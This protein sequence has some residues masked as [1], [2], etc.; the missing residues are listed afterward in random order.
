MPKIDRWLITVVPIAVLFACRMLGL[1]L[2]IPVF[3]IYAGQLLHATPGLIGV[4]LGA[5]GLGQGLLQLPM[6]LLSDNYGRKSILTY[7]FILLGLGSVIG[8]VTNSIW[9]IIA[10]R[11][12]Q[13]S[14]AIGSVLMALLAD[15][16]TV[17]ARTKGMA[18]IGSTIGLSF[19]LA[20]VVSPVI[21]AHFGL[22]GIFY[23]SL[24]LAMLGLIIV[25]YIKAPPVIAVA[26]RM[27]WWLTLRERCVTSLADKQLL[28]LNFGI[29]FQ[30]WI[31]TAT[32]YV[33]PLVLQKHIASGNLEHISLFYLV[34][35]L[36]A[37]ALMIPLIIIS[38]KHGYIRRVLRGSIVGTAIIQGVLAVNYQH[39]SFLCMLMVLYFAMFNV[40]EALLPSLTSKQAHQAH[41]GTAMGIYSTFQ[42]LGI[43]A[44][45]I[46]SGVIFA[47]AGYQ[48]VFYLNSVVAMIWYIS[49]TIV[50]EEMP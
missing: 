17:Q 2:L 14:G 46:V 47:H 21:A 6:G 48:A 41:K 11:I 50:G 25:H 27:N 40:L 35:L 20:M 12:L 8:A 31:L 16:T 34:I 29:F 42:F 43:F 1:F 38:E 18:I 28:T 44:G 7:G 32:F 45:G 5:Y 9:G 15:I 33:L 30:H 36:S 24:L 37:F 26:T 13:G 49:T 39:W 4:A 19:A 3:T 10:A 22:H 23:I